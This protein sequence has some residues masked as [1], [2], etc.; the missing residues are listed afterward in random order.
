MVNEY[1]LS[2]YNNI[3]YVGI[4]FFLVS[5]GQAFTWREQCSAK[6]EFN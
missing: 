2:I 3:F 6:Q 1:T 5:L 4:V